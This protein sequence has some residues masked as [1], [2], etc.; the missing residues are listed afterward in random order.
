MKNA[1]EI[2]D[3]QIE[4]RP[5]DEYPSLE[6][7]FPFLARFSTRY[8]AMKMTSN[9]FTGSCGWKPKGPSVT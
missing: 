7:F 8:A 3:A 1:L 2:R 9:S 6:R 4:D 5:F